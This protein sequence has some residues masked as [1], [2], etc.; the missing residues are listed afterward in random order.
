MRKFLLNDGSCM[1]VADDPGPGYLDLWVY[2]E[3]NGRREMVGH[4]NCDPNVAG[5]DELE[6]LDAI[7]RQTGHG[8]IAGYEEN[9]VFF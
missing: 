8:G 4:V 9:V 5:K 3:Q 7:A 2:V 1:L 6:V